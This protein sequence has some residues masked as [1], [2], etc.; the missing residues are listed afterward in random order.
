[1][2]TVKTDREIQ[3]MRDAGRLTA[4][5]MEL[6]G[7]LVK[8]GVSTKEIDDRLYKFIKK[9]NATPSFLNYYGY[10]ATACISVNAVV[11]HGIPSGQ[12]IIADGDIVS[13]DVGV[14][15]NGYHG[16]MA[17]TF[18]AGNV[19]EEAKKLIEVT[20]ESFWRGI[21]KATDGARV[22]DIGHAIESYVH[23]NG[24]SVVEDYVGHGVGTHLHE[25][26][27]VPNYGKPGRGM[28]LRKGMTIAVEPMINAGCA[29]VV[30]LKDGWTVVTKD[31]K[32]SAHYENT[33]AITDGEPLILTSL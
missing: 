32:L 2:I 24:F 25:D 8:P 3:L 1:M 29:D 20:K 11:I 12:R 13:I 30:Q 33:I 26:P 18:C 28:R 4:E 16:D 9:H 27:D 23:E 6:A 21:A 14:L 5:V 22:G 7:S 17:R 15:L 10:P 31:G 19:S